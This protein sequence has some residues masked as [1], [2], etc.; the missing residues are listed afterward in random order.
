MFYSTKR[1]SL[2][3]ARSCSLDMQQLEET[4][5]KSS[6]YGS[7]GLAAGRQSDVTLPVDVDGQ[8]EGVTL[9]TAGCEP[10]FICKKEFVDRRSE[11]LNQSTE[12][13][14]SSGQY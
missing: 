3:D 6:P 7:F 1:S 9:H 5:T 10:E 4:L 13:L 8:A 11:S 2:L 14:F 12:V